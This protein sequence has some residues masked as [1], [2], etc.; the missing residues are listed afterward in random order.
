MFAINHAATALIIKKKYQD[1]PMVWLLVSVQFMELIWVFFNYFGIE[2]TTTENVVSYVGDVHL[3]YMPFSHSVVTML[4]VAVLAW[5]IISK[6]FHNPTIGLAVGI[7]IAS[8][9]ILDLVTHASD[10]A[11][12]PAFDGPKLG[13]GLYASFPIVAFLLEFAYGVACWWIYRGSKGLLVVIVVFNLAN[14]SMF[15]AAIPGLEGFL[16]N[17]PMVITTVIFLQIVITLVL[18]GIYSK[19][20]SSAVTA[21]SL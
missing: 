13:L 21:Q 19:R 18:V 10:M 15:S 16:A 8:H 5:L 11:I 14:L 17:Q 6:V 7:G 9:L 3:L 1:V 12:A 2:R 4:G 20:K